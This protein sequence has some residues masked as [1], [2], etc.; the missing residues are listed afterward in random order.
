MY[1]CVSHA[2]A[3]LGFPP[4]AVPSHLRPS[5]EASKPPPATTTSH[6]IPSLLAALREGSIPERQQ[7]LQRLR[8]LSR[9]GGPRQFESVFPQFLMGI[10][11][12]LQ[13]T[14]SE[15]VATGLFVL[16]TVCRHQPT[17]LNDFLE[18]TLEAV[19]QCC[20]D[21]SREVCASFCLCLCLCVCPATHSPHAGLGA[22]TRSVVSVGWSS[23][24]H[25]RSRRRSTAPHE[26]G[27]GA[28]AGA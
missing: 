20:A 7:A 10:L 3:E 15:L 21:S 23:G 19:L 24:T 17:R 27:R 8:R 28:L 25:T 18:M 9:E 2:L 13:E 16:R 6:S 5:V 1:V 26:R 12:T 14:S 4:R 22:G 11:A